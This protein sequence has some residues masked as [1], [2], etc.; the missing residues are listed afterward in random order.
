MA[1]S[2]TFRRRGKGNNVDETFDF[3]PPN[4][5]GADPTGRRDDLA[6][7][8]TG[9][10]ARLS[11][12]ELVAQTSLPG[13]GAHK[14]ALE[15]STT[16]PPRATPA[17]GTEVARKPVNE[18]WLASSSTT[19]LSR[20]HSRSSDALEAAVA[21]ASAVSASARVASVGSNATFIIKKTES[22]SDSGFSSVGNSADGGESSATGDSFEPVTEEREDGKDDPEPQSF[23]PRV[24][25]RRLVVPSV[26]WEPPTPTS[27]TN[28]AAIEAKDPPVN[29]QQSMRRSSSAEVSREHV[30]HGLPTPISNPPS[31]PPLEESASFTAF[32]ARAGLSSSSSS[33]GSFEHGHA[34]SSRDPA[35]VFRVCRDGRSQEVAAF[36][37]DGAGEQVFFWPTLNEVAGEGHSQPYTANLV[38]IMEGRQEV[39]ESLDDECDFGTTLVCALSNSIIHSNVVLRDRVGQFFARAV[40][41]ARIAKRQADE[42]IRAAESR[43]EVVDGRDEGRHREILQSLDRIRLG[44]EAVRSQD[45]DR[46]TKGFELLRNTVNSFAEE[47]VAALERELH[48][49]KERLVAQAKAAKEEAERRL[50]AAQKDHESSVKAVRQDANERIQ[51]M[52]IRI[53][54]VQREADKSRKDA[55]DRVHDLQKEI[56]RTRKDGVQRAHELAKELEEARKHADEERTKLARASEEMRK[57]HELAEKELKHLREELDKAKDKHRKAEQDRVE[58]VANADKRHRDELAKQRQDAEELKHEVRSSKDEIG[59]ERSEVE[60]AKLHTAK[61]EKVV[62]AME[63]EVQQLRSE[64]E[65]VQRENQR[66]AGEAAEG[67][68]RERAADQRLEQAL[69]EL[70]KVKLLAELREEEDREGKEDPGVAWKVDSSSQT[71]DPEL[72][73]RRL[74]QLAVDRLHTAVTTVSSLDASPRSLAIVASAI[75]VALLAAMFGLLRSGSVSFSDMGSAA[76]SKASCGAT[77][78][79]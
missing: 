41:T 6:W 24:T 73:W 18:F 56:E 28:G 64:M 30:P 50:A 74:Q 40:K 61:L 29:R 11:E 37:K 45:V 13:A 21:E 23:V 54:E 10:R 63:I 43:A 69:I 36:V 7:R 42:K 9:I 25:V 62:D 65:V 60:K 14:T 22:T 72:D 5:G 66:L 75:L 52:Q 49:G 33:L 39:L 1:S 27:A 51:D 34:M 79:N 35:T 77:G 31:A 44:S 8:H 67:R 15:S 68:S 55:Q 46:V 48:D 59:R 12:S 47:R 3:G 2:S 53:Q 70:H 26:H 20:Q 38:A 16:N 78:C 32:L 19:N 76:L 17:H 58:A 71:E 57:K 4:R